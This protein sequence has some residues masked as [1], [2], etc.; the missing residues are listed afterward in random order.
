MGDFV[1]DDLTEFRITSFL[2][3]GVADAAEVEIGTVSDVNFIFIRPADEA[4]VLIFGFHGA[5]L[6]SKGSVPS[7]D[8]A[9]D[10]V[11]GPVF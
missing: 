7:S 10:W 5:L 8:K 4:V 1:A 11:Q 6:R 9:L 3:L 2:G